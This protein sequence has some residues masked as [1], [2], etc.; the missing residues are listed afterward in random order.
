MPIASVLKC[1]GLQTFKNALSELD[2][3]AL[4]KANNVVIDRDSVIES[5][6][7]F[8]LYGD[9]MTSPS[10]QLLVYKDRILRHFGNKMQF[11]NGSGVFTTFQITRTGNTYW[12]TT[13]DGLSTTA[14]L[15]V[16]MIVT[17]SNVP[18]NTTII[19]IVNANSITISNSTTSVLSGV[20]LVFEY[21][22]LEAS[23]EMRIKYVEI[24]G[25][26]FFTSSKGIKKISAE[27]ASDITSTS[28]TNAGIPK[29]LDVNTTLNSG[30]GFFDQDS[31]VAYRVLWGIK[32]NNNNLVLGAPS[33]RSVIY[34]AVEN[35]LST[36][37]NSLLS[38]LD[39]QAQK[40]YNITL[41]SPITVDAG[42]KYSY[43]SQNYT[44][45]KT[46]T[47]GTSLILAGKGTLPPTS[48]TLTKVTTGVGPSTIFYNIISGPF[49]HGINDANYV[50]NLNSYGTPLASKLKQGL[51]QLASKIDSDITLPTISSY[52]Y[53]APTLTIN[54][55]RDLTG[56]LAAGD[57][58]KITGTNHNG[59][60]NITSVSGSSATVKTINTYAGAGAETAQRLKYTVGS[61][62]TNSTTTI[63]VLVAGFELKDN[64][65]YIRFSSDISSYVYPGDTINVSGLLSTFADCNGTHTV[66]G[67]LKRTTGTFDTIQINYVR[68][69]I[70]P[71]DVSSNVVNSKVVVAGASNQLVLSTVPT[72][73]QLINLQTYYSAIVSA[74]QIEPYGISEGSDFDARAA[75]KSATA[76]LSFSVPSGIT[77]NHFYQ[78]YRTYLRTASGVEVLS[79]LDPGDEQKLVYEGNPTSGEIASGSITL[80]D[81]TPESFLGANLYT[82]NISGEGLLQSNDT[83]PFAHDISVYKNYTFYANTKT[84]YR[85]EFSLLSVSSFVSGVS[86]FSITNGTTINNY[87]FYDNVEDVSTKKVKYI[88]TTTDSSITISQQVDACARSL[89]KLINKNPNEIVYAYYL[90]GS[91]DV[92]GQILLESRVFDTTPFRISASAGSS[93]SPNISLVSYADNEVKLNRI[94]YSKY[95]QPD[96]VPMLNYLDIGPKDK[97]IKRILALR[98][99]LFILKEEAVYRLS[100][101]TAPFTVAMFDNSTNI[102]APDSACVLNNQIFAM[103]RQGVVSISEA[104]ISITSRA[105]E[106][107]LLPLP[108]Y[109]NFSSS[110]FGVAY[111]S[112]RS[113][114]LFTVSSSSDS[115]ATQC[116]RY[117]TFTNTWTILNLEKTC[118]LVS[119]T[120]DKMY[121]GASDVNYIEIERKDFSRT[122]YADREIEVNVV[123]NDVDG[124]Q[125]KITTG[126]LNLLS[127]G[128]VLLQT[129]Y[130]TVAQFN[131]VLKKLD[132]DSGV[133]DSNYFSTIQAF[134]GSNLRTR[135]IALCAKLDADA[136]VT[137]TNYN[138][139]PDPANIITYPLT[140]AGDQAAFNAIVDKLNA[141]S[142]I[143]YSNYPKSVGTTTQE[144]KIVGINTGSYVITTEYAYPF[145]Y[146]T[147]FVHNHI[148]TEV[149]WAPNILGDATQS[150]QVRESTVL[151]Q[152]TSFSEAKVSFSTDISGS[153]EEA[154]FTGKGN[155]SFGNIPFGLST[156]GGSGQAAPIRTFVP[157]NK[158]RCRYINCNFKHQIARERF[159]IY[160]INYVF[161]VVSTRAYRRI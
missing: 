5:R 34:N 118:G 30:T 9:V 158:Q 66:T 15:S 23:S 142:G 85:K 98:D 121:L 152:D 39:T 160:G 25:N 58:I 53:V 3:G 110:T 75:K 11:D 106:D 50:S 63:P 35:L 1:S 100:G 155:G 90:S 149:E 43:S 146:G 127:V 107:L 48:A 112:S 20:S 61:F 156:Y 27:T 102:V 28:I 78:V 141:D 143:N 33:G 95:Q 46:V 92:P 137:D 41:G 103:T 114:Y 109:T 72:S 128:D 138:S 148:K 161:E 133:N 2:A 10:K 24:N 76:D 69:N 18:A 14:D 104:G 4:V 94:Y 52:T 88:S 115:V 99:S 57:V 87:T 59:I 36:D 8:K 86:V 108:S 105:I 67:V 91:D 130:L 139:I 7:G 71:E 56:I 81:I 140:F 129:Q 145:I 45:V 54:F 120:Q 64:Y 119:P 79:D 73:E 147:A 117:N 159:S 157:R 136:G 125:V 16:G 80:T 49:N 101:E 132:L 55:S 123:E 32:D 44:V 150:K 151:F 126:D 77:E 21:N 74:L 82:N 29:A 60:Y 113:Y 83:P 111:E 93:F 12:N 37:Y 144:A 13:I 17:G 96:S 135:L 124:T 6:R 122:D 62:R 116:F 26:L 42:Q 134:P 89:V 51:I 38:T 153:V 84:K 40:L 19:A 131:R 97:E 68:S 154:T 65:M 47:A 22:I 31:V 70:T